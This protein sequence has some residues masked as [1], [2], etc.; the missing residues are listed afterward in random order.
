VPLSLQ[1]ASTAENTIPII[2]LIPNFLTT[3]RESPNDGRKEAQ[4]VADQVF[5]LYPEVYRRPEFTNRIS[6]ERYIPALR[7]HLP[8]VET[9]HERLLRVV[10]EIESSFI[11]SFPDFNVSRCKIFFM[12]SLF[13]FDGKIPHEH[14]NELF[15]GV[16]GIARFHGNEANLPVILSHELFH[17]YHFQVTPPPSDPDKIALYQQVWQEGLATYVSHLLNPDAPLADVFLDPRLANEGPRFV[18]QAAKDLMM[19]LESIDD[20]DIAEYLRYRRDGKVPARLGYLLGFK[21]VEHLAQTRRIHDLARL[22]GWRLLRTIQTELRK[23][24]GK[25]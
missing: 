23:L 7:S 5:N 16:D 19:K 10:P 18:P 15:L 14:R 24:G 9:V 6:L 4:L 25:S 22:R 11:K 20:T 3:L 8:M 12:L 21:I 1:G 13:Q 2:D 17:L